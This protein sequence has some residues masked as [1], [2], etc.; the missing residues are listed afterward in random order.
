M[1]THN[2][3]NILII[4]AG[5][6]GGSLAKAARCIGVKTINAACRSLKS[7][8]KTR[9]TNIFD[10][11]SANLF[12]KK[13]CG[14][15]DLI[16]VCSPVSKISEII[17]N[18]APNVSES[19][20]ITDVGSIKKNISSGIKKEYKKLFIGSH[21]MAGSEK[22]G[23]ENADEH[24]YEN[25]VVIVTQEKK[26]DITKMRRLINFWESLKSCVKI[27]DSD[28]HDKIV[29]YISHLPHITAAALVNSAATPKLSADVLQF[30]G[31]G[32]KD[33]TRIASSSAELWK[34]ICLNNRANIMPSI[35]TIIN[36]LTQFKNAL[37]N[38]NEI[39]LVKLFS[40][41]AEV[42]DKIPAKQKSLMNIVYEL[43]VNVKDE[44]GALG[45]LT[46]ALGKHKINIKHIEVL[47][48]REGEQGAI[49]LGFNDSAAMD[50]TYN[51]L[52]KYKYD[53]FK[54]T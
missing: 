7:A 50:K 13:L 24:L 49:K 11:V 53:T 36:E 19:S 29:A 2:F 37:A 54:K 46:T 25:A 30:A 41:A 14:S 23:V 10:K 16:V 31:G 22:F 39:K 18:I 47:N 44:P 26:T 9:K 6:M 33:T 4:S 12:D 8:E 45:K 1:S 15:A 34:D 48:V 40:N 32:F 21:P 52:T 3:S 51:I 38:K 43:I 28:T 20:I 17:N 42:R 27:L 5:L 35:D